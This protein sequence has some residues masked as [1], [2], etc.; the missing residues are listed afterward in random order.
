MNSELCQQIVKKISGDLSV[1]LN[2]MRNWV[3]QK[4]KARKFFFC[5]FTKDRLKKKNFHV[6]KKQSPDPNLCLL[7]TAQ[8]EGLYTFPLT[9]V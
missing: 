1:S 7:I 8:C 5:F 2:L 4:D 3:M 9:N 6:L